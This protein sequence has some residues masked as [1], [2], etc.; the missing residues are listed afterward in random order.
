MLT[1]EE[2]IKNIISINLGIKLEEVKNESHL[3]DELGADSLDRVELM[4]TIE[5]EFDGTIKDSEAQN[6]V[7]VGQIIDFVNS[8]LAIAREHKSKD[9]KE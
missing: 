3:F 4:M 7:T 6:I 5:E 2:R 8:K 9:W 1:V